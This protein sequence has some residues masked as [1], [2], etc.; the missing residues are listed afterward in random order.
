MGLLVRLHI[1]LLE[2]SSS[3]RLLPSRPY[4]EMPS[5]LGM[6]SRHRSSRPYVVGIDSGVGG[7]LVLLSR[8]GGGGKGQ[9][10]G[11]R[12]SYFLR[13]VELFYELAL[14]LEQRAVVLLNIGDRVVVVA[15]VVMVVVPRLGAGGG[16]RHLLALGGRDHEIVNLVVGVGVALRRREI[17]SSR[18]LF[19]R[20]PRLPD[21]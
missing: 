8:W 21:I 13:L 7:G 1:L 9:I 14:S 4:E 6:R 5:R 12:Y 17:F 19:I 18:S 16:Q 11:G 15:R 10:G 20:Y 2:G 3:A